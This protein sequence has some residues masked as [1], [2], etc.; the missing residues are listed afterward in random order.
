MKVL[1]STGSGIIAE[2]TESELAYLTGYQ[3]AYD[4][5]F[6]RRAMTA[7]GAELKIAETF[8]QL[9][10]LA[11][12]KPELERIAK[13]LRTVSELLEACPLPMI[14]MPDYKSGY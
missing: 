1:G 11:R 4:K 8:H 2:L 6:D 9:E 10:S 13:T 12:A 5:R 3:S 14:T 7:A